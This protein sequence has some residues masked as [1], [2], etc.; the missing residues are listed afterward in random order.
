MPAQRPT[1]P[2]PTR[3]RSPRA[4]PKTALDSLTWE[5]VRDEQG[6]IRRTVSMTDPATNAAV[7]GQAIV[8]RTKAHDGVVVTKTFRLGKNIDGL[9]VQL[10]FESPDK[11][12]KVVYNL[13]GPQGIPI[14]GEWYTG[15]FRDL[16]FGQLN[17][18]RIKTETYSAND[19]AKAGDKPPDNTALP[20][21]YSG[22]ENQ[23][24]ATLMEPVPLPK[25]LEDRWDSRTVALWHRDAAN[26]DALHK[27]DIGVRLTSR[28]IAVA[29]AQPVVHT[30]RV[31]AGPKIADALRPYTPRTSPRTARTSGSRS[32]PISR[33]T[34]SP[35]GW[36]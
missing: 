6:Q 10:Q 36:T 13:R 9:E 4:T 11:E 20:L 17:Q 19:V 35:P 15:T 25:G 29:P 32:H 7:E 3:W 28:P 1:I 21:A 22:V 8:F 16:F 30:Y 34:S 27:S 33:A 26:K 23:Y 18:D 31:F 12:R 2:P 24:F 14:E 5:V